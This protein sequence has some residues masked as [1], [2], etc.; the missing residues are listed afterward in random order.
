MPRMK[1]DDVDLKILSTLQDHGR[2]TNVDLAEKVGITAPP[3]LRRVR[4]LEETGHIRGYHADLDPERLGFG[5]TVIAMI[6]LKSQTDVDLKA[7]EEMT[8]NWPLVRECYLLNGDVDFL[9]KIVA[10][11]LGEYQRFLT[12]HLTSAP[13]VGSIKT[14]LMIRASKSAPGVPV[15]LL[16]APTNAAG[17]PTGNA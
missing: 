11:D 1:I 7:F 5:I 12:N 9:L 4:G 3:C 10:R 8:H 13:G 17:E 15:E 16:S 14:A 6:S 2:M